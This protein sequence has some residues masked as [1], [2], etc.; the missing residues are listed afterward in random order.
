MFNAKVPSTPDPFRRRKIHGLS[1]HLRSIVRRVV[2]RGSPCLG[3]VLRGDFRHESEERDCTC[4][5]GWDGCTFLTGR[6]V[7]KGMR[8]GVSGSQ[9]RS[10]GDSQPP[11]SVPPPHTD[12]S[13]TGYPHSLPTVGRLVDSWVPWH[14]RVSTGN[15]IICVSVVVLPSRD[16]EGQE[17]IW[18]R[19]RGW[20][21]AKTWIFDGG[22]FLSSLTSRSL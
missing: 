20:D 3:V 9:E 4:G 21:E 17:G 15:E 16:D 6:S 22:W 1:L 7:G 13:N 11:V 10:S 2:V 5:S 8:K 14:S 12:T 19:I 18:R